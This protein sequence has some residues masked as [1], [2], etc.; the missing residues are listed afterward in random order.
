VVVVSTA[1]WAKF[2]DSVLKAILGVP[3]A[4]DLPEPY[5]GLSG[6]EMLDAVQASVGEDAAPIPSFLA[7]LKDMQERFT[8]VVEPGRSSVEDS[9][10]RWLKSFPSD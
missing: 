7:E 6:F 5:L 8:S 2:G 9:L 4:A 10:L 1:A 3:Y